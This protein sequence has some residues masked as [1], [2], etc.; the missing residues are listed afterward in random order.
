MK[1]IIGIAFWAIGIYAVD[2]TV[3]AVVDGFVSGYRIGEHF[4]ER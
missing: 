3:R 1:H 2:F 4:D